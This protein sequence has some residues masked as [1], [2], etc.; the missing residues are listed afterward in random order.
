MSS[1]HEEKAF[2]ADRKPRRSNLSDAV[3]LAEPIYRSGATIL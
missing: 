2:V 3:T 1:F